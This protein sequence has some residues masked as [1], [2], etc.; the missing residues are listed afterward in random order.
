[1]DAAAVA[2]LTAT[3]EHGSRSRSRSTCF[4]QVSRDA[5]TSHCSHHH[6]IDAFRDNEFGE[7]VFNTSPA[8]L[9]LRPGD[10]VSKGLR[11]RR[12]VL[13]DAMPGAVQVR[14]VLL[15]RRMA[16]HFP[17]RERLPCVQQNQR[18]FLESCQKERQ[19]DNPAI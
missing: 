1:M 16:G 4:P 10:S 3:N 19:F 14:G 17:L 13:L 8:Q 9:N 5:R 6:E 15:V 12:E 2:G 7:Y 18:A 11:K